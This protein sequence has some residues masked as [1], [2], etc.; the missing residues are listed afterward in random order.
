VKAGSLNIFVAGFENSGGAKLLPSR[1]DSEIQMTRLKLKRCYHDAIIQEIR[2]HDKS[3]VSIDVALC[4]CCNPSQSFATVY[5]FGLRNFA[6]F[7]E[8]LETVR[9]S[10]SGRGYIDEI[11]GIARVEGKYYLLDLMFAGPVRADARN[12]SEI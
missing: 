11:V 4:N 2:Y 6:E 3:D 10:S 7:Q 8:S 12:L 1:I 5:F 9:Q